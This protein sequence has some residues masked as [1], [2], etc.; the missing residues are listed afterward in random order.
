MDF[1]LP[2]CKKIDATLIS[3]KLIGMRPDETWEH[4]CQRHMLEQRVK[5]INKIRDKIKK[6]S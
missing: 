2:I 6:G 4:A 5:K 3:D 1:L